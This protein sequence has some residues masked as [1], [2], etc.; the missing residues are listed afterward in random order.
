MLTALAALTKHRRQPLAVVNTVI[1]MLT[2][3]FDFLLEGCFVGIGDA[4]NHLRRVFRN[5]SMLWMFQ[6]DIFRL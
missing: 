1:E 6:T 5:V 2:P 3:T 4:V